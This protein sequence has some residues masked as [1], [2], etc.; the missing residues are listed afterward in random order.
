MHDNTAGKG[1]RR[2]ETGRS[3]EDYYFV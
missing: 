1:E 3:I 2:K